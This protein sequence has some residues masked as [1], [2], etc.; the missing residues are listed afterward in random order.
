MCRHQ[1]EK[2]QLWKLSAICALLQAALS[3]FI[4]YYECRSVGKITEFVHLTRALVSEWVMIR[5]KDVFVAL[6][7]DIGQEHFLK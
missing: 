2:D 1:D 6:R 4:N 3:A 5:S 7:C